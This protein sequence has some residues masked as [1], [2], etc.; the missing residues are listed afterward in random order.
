MRL[1]LAQVEQSPSASR[2]FVWEVRS[3][4]GGGR[5]TEKPKAHSE[6]CRKV[7]QGESQAG[8][9]CG[10]VVCGGKGNVRAK[11]E[12]HMAWIKPVTEPPPAWGWGQEQQACQMSSCQP[13]STEPIPAAAEAK[14][15][16]SQEGEHAGSALGGLGEFGRS[17][18]KISPQL[19][20]P[21]YT[22]I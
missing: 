9:V 11:L 4:V 7:L 14:E 1:R 18:T 13:L 2:P 6:V 10:T 15:V 8:F 3:P 21:I 17:L 12:L 16:G 22:Y 19:R 5:C 20:V